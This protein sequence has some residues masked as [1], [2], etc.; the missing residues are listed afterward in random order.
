MAS[1]GGDVAGDD[2]NDFGVGAPLLVPFWSGDANGPDWK[3]PKTSPV[4]I[5]T[6]D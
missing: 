2:R 1:V 3:S 5:Q 4:M 6:S